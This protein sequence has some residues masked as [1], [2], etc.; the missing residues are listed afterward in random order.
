MV[1]TSVEDMLDCGKC[2]KLVFD[3]PPENVKF[4]LRVA[5]TRSSRRENSHGC[6]LLLV[7]RFFQYIQGELMHCQFDLHLPEEQVEANR[8]MEIGERGSLRGKTE[9]R[10]REIET[11][12]L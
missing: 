1:G 4:S 11:E 3:P 5:N 8:Q 2:N 10:E 9:R 7:C 12:R 6:G